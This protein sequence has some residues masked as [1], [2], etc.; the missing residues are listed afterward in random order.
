[1]TLPRYCIEKFVRL[2]VVE[3]LPDNYTF[4]LLCGDHGLVTSQYLRATARSRS[5]MLMHVILAP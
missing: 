5:E 4:Q 1:M 2:F 3:V